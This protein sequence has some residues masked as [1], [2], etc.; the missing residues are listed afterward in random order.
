MNCSLFNRTARVASI[1][2][3]LGL[4]LTNTTDAAEQWSAWGSIVEIEAGWAQDTMAVYHSPSV[5]VNPDGCRVTTAGYATNPA[6]PGHSLFHAV[7]LSAL[8]NKKEV[9]FLI[10]GC[11]FDKPRIIAVKVH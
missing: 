8:M 10:S 2:I 11:V 5:T 4:A 1:V 3:G 7:T 9:A 6:D